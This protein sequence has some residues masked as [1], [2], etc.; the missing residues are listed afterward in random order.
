MS[1]QNLTRF[2][3]GR[4]CAVE[5]AS[6]L[7][8]GLAAAHESDRGV[9]VLAGTNDPGNNQVLVYRPQ[10]GAAPAPSLVQCGVQWGRDQRAGCSTLERRR[11]SR[12]TRGEGLS[13]VIETA[14]GIEFMKREAAFP[15]RLGRGLD[16]HARSCAP[17]G[18]C[19]ARIAVEEPTG[20][21]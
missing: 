21:G 3:A 9:L 20:Q 1:L 7:A 8:A 15:V 10:T 11:T 6:L 19:A 14:V 17:L 13:I 5:A 4:A 18:L 16:A 12:L 2:L